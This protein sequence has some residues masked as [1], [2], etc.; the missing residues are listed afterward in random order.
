[1]Q[2]RFGMHKIIILTRKTPLD[3]YPTGAIEVN[4]SDNGPGFES[5]DLARFLDPFFTTNPLGTGLGLP[6]VNSIVTSHGGTL[7]I[8]NLPAL[9][10]S[11]PTSGALVRIVLPCTGKP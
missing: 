3:T 5:G 6:I 10:D 2:A 7:E 11:E 8:K 4:I 9:K 1:M